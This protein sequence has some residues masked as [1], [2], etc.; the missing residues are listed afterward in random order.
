MASGPKLARVRHLSYFS[1]SHTHTPTVI[2][3]C[4]LLCPSESIEQKHFH[5]RNGHCHS[6]SINS[7][8]DAV[9]GA[10]FSLTLYPDLSGPLVAL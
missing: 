9:R 5:F 2:N 7:T 1:P 8:E 10:L 6:L 3:G 4:H